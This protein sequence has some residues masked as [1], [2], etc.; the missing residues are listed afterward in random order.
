M[1]HCIVVLP[2]LIR[3]NKKKK[4]KL[5]WSNFSY[6]LSDVSLTV[7]ETGIWRV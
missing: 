7:G 2:V 5:I 3:L 6:Q 4:K 1:E